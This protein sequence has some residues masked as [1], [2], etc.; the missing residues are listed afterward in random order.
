MHTSITSEMDEIIIQ[1]DSKFIPLGEEDKAEIIIGVLN[2]SIPC[3]VKT[4]IWREENFV[5]VKHGRKKSVAVADIE[6]I[7]VQ[8]DPE[9]LEVNEEY[10]DYESDDC[11]SSSSSEEDEE[12]D[13]DDDDE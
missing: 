9:L 13:W 11:S 7:D 3:F 12:D 10:F 5:F 8:L 6:Y 1:F 4:Y 2:D